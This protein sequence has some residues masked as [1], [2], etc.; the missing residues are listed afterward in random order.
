MK[1][2]GDPKVSLENPQGRLRVSNQTYRE[3]DGV[4]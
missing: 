3:L 1:K 2:G 4:I